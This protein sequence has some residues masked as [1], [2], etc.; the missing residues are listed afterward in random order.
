MTLKTRRFLFYGL[1]I[2]FILAGSGAVLYSS[3]WRF[4]PANFHFRKTGAIYI[5][6]EPKDAVIKINNIYFKNLSGLIKKG[7]LIS[8]LPPQPYKIEL[9]KEGYLPYYKNL[10][11]EPSLVSEL[12]DVILI[13]R[14]IKKEPLDNSKKIKGDEF[15][16]ISKDGG[17]IALKESESGIY[18]LYDLNNLSTAFNVN[19][20]FDNASAK[21]KTDI[22]NIAFHPFE[23]D[24]IVIE[25]KKGLK[26]LDTNR[27]ILNIAINE[28]P[29][30]WTVGNSNIYYLTKTKNY[31]IYSYNLILKTKTAISQKS[32]ALENGSEIKKIGVDD[33]DN[34]IAILDNF[35]DIYVFNPS[36]Q[37]LLKIAHS[38][39]YF[40][41]SP[42]SK[43]IA[44]LDKDGLIGVY[45]LDDWRKGINKK[46][47]D[48][49]RL[50]LKNPVAEQV[51][52]GAS[53]SDIKNIIWQENSAHLF[54]DYGNRLDF[55][56]I[57]DRLPL[58]QYTIIDQPLPFLY[59]LKN[60]L[61]YFI[62]N[63][64]LWKIEL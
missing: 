3:G 19:A 21:E 63:N 33:S 44:F 57:D 14:E 26:I 38:A 36:N 50:D 35:D 20:A 7:T 62:Q 29:T 31:T 51:R 17:K 1:F 2:V 42:D 25:T 30:V 55:I 41:F 12:I 45:F 58:N 43:K 32:L 40:S 64:S 27:L 34:K 59:D 22:I 18:Y 48:V 24:K 13:H 23:S 56:E 10:Q 46:A 52:Y 37:E 47:G 9:K 54:V 5:E 53:K 4:N 28:R 49:I 60:N 61:I 16:A 6:T 39:K 15:I 11:V 8:N